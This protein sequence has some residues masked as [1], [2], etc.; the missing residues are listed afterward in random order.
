ML[1]VLGTSLDMSCFIRSMNISGNSL[2]IFT[3]SDFEN[4]SFCLDGF[5]GFVF[6][7]EERNFLL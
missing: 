3:L 6:G 7:F 2:I 5:E 1:L 4:K